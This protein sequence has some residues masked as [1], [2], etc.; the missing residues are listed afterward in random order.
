[1]SHMTGVPQFGKF[2]CK[3]IVV[4]LNI[5]NKVTLSYKDYSR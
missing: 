1:M 2:P 4:I 5:K 3:G